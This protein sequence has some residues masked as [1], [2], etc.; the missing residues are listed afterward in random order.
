MKIRWNTT[1]AFL[2]LALISLECGNNLATNPLT[3]AGSPSNVTAL[4]VDRTTVRLFW[5]APAGA[6][7]STIRSYIIQWPGNRD[8]VPSGVFTFTADSLLPGEHAFTLSTERT[9]GS[10]SSG[11]VINWAPAARFDSGWVVLEYDPAI[12]QIEGFHVGS[13]LGHP[14]VMTLDPSNEQFVDLY[15]FGRAGGDLVMLSASQYLQDWNATL[16]STQADAATSLDLPLPA[17]PAPSTF[18]LDNITL[19]DNTIYYARVIGLNGSFNYARIHIHLLGGVAPGR[20]VEVKVSL[21]TVANLPIAGSMRNE[22]D[23]SPSVALFL[24]PMR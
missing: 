15:F 21:Q 4:S 1:F 10:F 20:S 6:A 16:F 14:A 23:R 13:Q 11:T 17:F 18:T 2:L 24:H 22:T 12:N 19:T 5:S 8:S 9:D 7:D 3:P